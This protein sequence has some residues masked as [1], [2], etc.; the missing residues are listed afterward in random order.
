MT[1]FAGLIRTLVDAR[2]EFI[3]V[4]GV[5]ATV[6]GSARLTR[7]VD[8]VYARSPE[9]MRRLVDAL[10]SHDPYLRGAPQGLP[11][12]WDLDTIQRG[13]NFTLTTR[14]GDLD[15]LG[16]VTG[17]GGFEQLHD[18]ASRVRLFDRDVRCLD[19][20]WLIRVKRAAGRPR[21]LEA[22]AELEALR[23]ER[24]RD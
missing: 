13:L 15:L 17:G 23:E 9:N 2:V 8:V 6:H 16:E 7:D 24:D 21:D 12:R 5:A 20:D 19:L 11:F 4:G 22:I 18:H 1:D 3:L 14:L 10:A